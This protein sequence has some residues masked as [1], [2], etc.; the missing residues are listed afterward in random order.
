MKIGTRN[1]K[2]GWLWLGLFVILGFVIEIV[3]V[4]NKKYAANYS[5]LE[6]TIGYTR[7]LLRTAH[8]HGNLLSVLNIIYGLFIDKTTL[9]DGLKNTGSWLAIAG[10][11]IMPL[12]L[13]A[14]GFG[15]SA[16]GPLSSLGGLA[17]IIAV[18]ILAIGYLR[19]SE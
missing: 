8:A 7:E 9:A 11:V 13:I 3:L 5:G 6:G 2:F 15:I 4:T 14:L 10:A 18:W 17:I 12:S 16:V 19:V 1:G